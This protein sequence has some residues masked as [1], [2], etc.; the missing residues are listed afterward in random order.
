MNNLKAKKYR[1]FLFFAFYTAIFTVIAVA[2]FVL[3]FVLD[4]TFFTTYDGRVQH[5][6]ALS[7]YGE[8][9]RSLFHSFFIEGK[10]EVQQ[11]D[12]NLG[13]G[14][15]IIQTLHYYVI[16]DP[17]SFLSVFFSTKNM[18]I[19]YNV[20]IFLRLYCIGIAFLAYCR[21]HKF[22]RQASLCGAFVYIFCGFSFFCAPRHPYFV[23]P[24]IWLPLLFIGIDKIFREKRILFFAFF[25]FVSTAS[26]FYFFYMLSIIVFVYALIR[27][28]FVFPKN[29]YKNIWR[30]ILLALAGYVLGVCMAAFLFFPNVSGFFLCG[31]SEEEKPLTF[32]YRPNYYIKM[33]LGFVAPSTFGS[34]STFGYAAPALP[35]TI[36]LFRMKDKISRQL[37]LSITIGLIFYLLPVFGC[38]F[39]GFSYPSNRWGF[40][41]SF[42]IAIGVSYVLPSAIKYTWKEIRSIMI[43]CILLCCFVFALSIFISDVREQF[44]LSYTVLFVTILILSAVYI[45]RCSVKIPYFILILIS[46]IFQANFRYSPR[47]LDYLSKGISTDE[48]VELQ[49]E[50]T[51]NFPIEDSEFCRVETACLKSPNAPAVSGIKGTTYYWS[52]NNGLLYEFYRDYNLKNNLLSSFGL[53]NNEYLFSLLN[54]KYYIVPAEK[55]ADIP[56]SFIDTGKNYIGYKIFENKN[57]QYFG[58]SESG[59]HLKNVKTSTNKL[60]AEISPEKDCTIFLS[61]PYSKYWNAKIDNKKTDIRLAKTAFMELTV[62]EGTHLIE[63]TYKN[64]SFILGVIVSVFCFIIFVTISVYNNFLSICKKKCKYETVTKNIF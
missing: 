58:F 54:V 30:Y 21:Y 10:F 22:D 34:Y 29:K 4:K 42:S 52:I 45:F 7:Y 9:L 51:T 50:Y 39:N 2:C 3:Y 12:F 57:F 37:K 48:Y 32:L 26:N 47:G 40:A 46:V 27:F 62:P 60:T 18:H 23:N 15:D 41:F 55:T 53:E 19:L 6:A 33:F 13:F 36:C 28:F 24:M 1:D 14:A 35:L 38:I 16:G 61:I 25:V 43:A 56:Q 20:N 5:I 64:N 31:R 59:E 44:L 11:W 49:R 17:F 8:Y 63:L